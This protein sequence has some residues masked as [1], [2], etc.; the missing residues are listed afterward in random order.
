[1]PFGS[2]Q[3][4]ADEAIANAMR[5]MKEGG[6]ESIKLEGGAR[7]ADTV[8]RMTAAGIPVMGHL[9]LTPQSVHQLGGWKVQGKTAEAADK[10][11]HDALLLQEAGAYAIVLETVPADVAERVT[12]AL[13]IP[14][15]GIGAGVGCDGQ[16]LVIYDLIGLNPEFTPRFLK[17]YANL[18]VDIMG[19]AQEYCAEVRSGAFPGE[20]HTY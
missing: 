16:V 10:L 15:I 8:R 4:G 6:A 5:L 18:G 13:E 14:T 11:V 3:A 1:M 12:S 20:E 9:G 7:V 17:R 2:Y 19:A